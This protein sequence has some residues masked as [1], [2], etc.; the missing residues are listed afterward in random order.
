MVGQPLYDVP[1]SSCNGIEKSPLLFCE[2]SLILRRP[3]LQVGDLNGPGLLPVHENVRF[4]CGCG[5]SVG[6]IPEV[7]LLQDDAGRCNIRVIPGQRK[8]LHGLLENTLQGSACAFND[9]GDSEQAVQFL[10]PLSQLMSEV[11][12][13]IVLWIQGSHFGVHSSTP[14]STWSPSCEGHEGGRGPFRVSSVGSYA[15]CGGGASRPS[16]E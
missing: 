14:V 4:L 13:G 3:R 10:H 15:F 5:F 16:R 1:H 9:V 12:R 6:L 8:E 2:R 7:V 11:G